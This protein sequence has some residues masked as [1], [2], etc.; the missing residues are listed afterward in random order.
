[1]SEN[2]GRNRF[3]V[4]ADPQSFDTVG[5]Q[6]S[7]QEVLSDNI[8]AFVNVEF[9]IGTSNIVSREGRLD[10]VGTGYIVLFQENGD[11]VV[12]DVFAI[13]FV[14]FLTSR[15]Y[16][17]TLEEPTASQTFMTPAQA[18]YSHAVRRKK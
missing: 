17:R 15:V 5:L 8:G 13:K 6:G 9:L 12:C 10:Y 7:M 16:P 4:P 3:Q 18:A 11:Y 1:M 14:N 2:Y